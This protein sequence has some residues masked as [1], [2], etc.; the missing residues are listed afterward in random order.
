MAAA[1]MMA[2][3][4]QKWTAPSSVGGDARLQQ[5]LDRVVDAREDHVAHEREDHRV[6]VQRAQP[7]EGEV[8]RDV[9][10]VVG[11]LEGDE[12]RP[13]SRR[14][15]TMDAHTKFRVISSL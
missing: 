1:T 3:Q 4:P 13:A 9:R 7:A 8:R 12:R 5:A 15:Q 2:C 10:P 14:P 11:E 6:G